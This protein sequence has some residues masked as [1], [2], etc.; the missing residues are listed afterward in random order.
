[1]SW[2][3]IEPGPPWW[4]AC[5]LA[6]SYSNSLLIAAVF[7]TSTFEPATSNFNIPSVGYRETK[8]KYHRIKLPQKIYKVIFAKGKNGEQRCEEEPGPGGGLPSSVGGQRCTQVSRDRVYDT[9]GI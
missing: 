4:G 6:N 1:M 8:Q 9:R 3:G 5:T 2:P 7:G